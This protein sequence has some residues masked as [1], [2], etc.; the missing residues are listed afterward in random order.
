ML[1]PP[2]IPEARNVSAPDDSRKNGLHTDVAVRAGEELFAEEPERYGGN[3]FWID[4]RAGGYIR[5]ESS[6]MV[7]FHCGSG[8][9]ADSIKIQ[10]ESNPPAKGVQGA[11]NE[12]CVTLWFPG[13]DTPSVELI[14][15]ELERLTCR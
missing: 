15:R 7:R 2:T 3:Q 12:D 1:I 5:V 11:A 13:L 10:P 4:G 9:V 6:V 14:I 8:V